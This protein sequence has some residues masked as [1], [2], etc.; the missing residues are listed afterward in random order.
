MKVLVPT[1]FS[2]CAQFAF[3][4]ACQLAESTTIE[5]HLYY[6]ADLPVNL[7]A[8]AEVERYYEMSHQTLAPIALRQLKELE[9][10]ATAQGIKCTTH[11]RE[12]K[13]LSELEVLVDDLSIDLVIMGS[14]GASGKSEWFVGSN[15]QKALRK[16]HTH[17]LVVKS[18]LQSMDFSK[19]LFATNLMVEDREAF[20]RFLQF[21]QLFPVKEVHILTVDT[22]SFFGSP[23]IVTRSALADFADMAS[24][25]KCFTH[26]SKDFSVD[27][28]IRS[29]ATAHAIQLIGMSNHQ[30]HPLR[31]WLL[32]SKVEFMINH[33]DIPVLSI[34]YKHQEMEPSHPRRL[35]TNN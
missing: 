34:D 11:Y 12:G 13:F 16:L 15:T 17:V 20:S 2:A 3:N 32:G 23:A 7:N 21:C 4:A 5:L 1:D 14:H 25:Y 22:G 8:S 9:D 31:H 28:G 6:A 30:R 24:A 19:V 29:F 33:A 27:Q 26:Q 35:F 10:Q 18:E